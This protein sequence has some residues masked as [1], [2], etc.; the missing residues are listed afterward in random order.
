MLYIKGIGTCPLHPATCTCMRST[1][2]GV[3]SMCGLN[4]YGFMR[5]EILIS[6]LWHQGRVCPAAAAVAVGLAVGVLPRQML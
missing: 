4:C 1:V 3:D 6:P 5:A 2:Q